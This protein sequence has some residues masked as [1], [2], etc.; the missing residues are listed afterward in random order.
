MTGEEK[1]MK[2]EVKKKARYMG[3]DK[4]TKMDVTKI[5]YESSKG[6][7]NPGRGNLKGIR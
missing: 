4:N 5:A 2:E 1:G 6:E 7:G 3:H